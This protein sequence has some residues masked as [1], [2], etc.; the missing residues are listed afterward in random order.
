MIQSNRCWNK[1]QKSLAALQFDT[2]FTPI[3]GRLLLLEDLRR[4]SDGSTDSPINDGMEIERLK[5]VNELLVVLQ[6]CFDDIYSKV[7]ETT[8][9][10]N[11]VLSSTFEGR[12]LQSKLMNQLN[13]IAIP[14]LILLEPKK[15]TSYN[16][17]IRSANY[18]NV[19]KAAKLLL[20]LWKCLKKCIESDSK[21]NSIECIKRLVLPI[22]VSCAMVL[23]SL[24]VARDNGTNKIV[25]AEGVIKKTKHHPDALDRGDDCAMAMLR[26]VQTIFSNSEG[27]VESSSMMDKDYQNKPQFSMLLSYEVANTIGGS[28]VARLVLG[29]LSL[30]TLES[31]IQNNDES[32]TNQPSVENSTELQLESLN[33]LCALISGI[34]MPELWRSIF[35]GCFA[36]SNDTF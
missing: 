19:E 33:T 28:L 18:A 15:D 4:Q 8:D 16:L 17:V 14:L 25:V 22:L 36:V 35:P 21:S 12:D 34:Y 3:V 27:D 6:G 7:D 26:L 13:G 11:I 20:S 10:S 1:Q 24:E 29:C 31:T 23:P 9:N 32:G 30:L 2:Q 5:Q